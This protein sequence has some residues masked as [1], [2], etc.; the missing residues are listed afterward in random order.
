[1]TDQRGNEPWSKQGM[2]GAFHELRVITQIVNDGLARKIEQM[3]GT[4]IIPYA[5]D[6]RN[7]S[8]EPPEMVV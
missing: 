6:S 7:G 5:Q 4:A 8:V 1:M 2:V 3:I